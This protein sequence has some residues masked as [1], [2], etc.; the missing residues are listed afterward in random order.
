[1]SASH[2]TQ[3]IAF[4]MEPNKIEITWELRSIFLHSIPNGEFS[5]SLWNQPCCLFL[6]LFFFLPLRLP[7]NQTEMGSENKTKQTNAHKI[8][9][10]ITWN[11][12][13]STKNRKTQ[14][15]LKNNHK[16]TKGAVGTPIKL[17]LKRCFV[18]I[19]AT[20][21]FRSWGARAYWGSQT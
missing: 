6:L 16:V 13:K 4:R 1:M 9:Y 14:N 7:I 11:T 19:F 17:T 5:T 18:T 21:A 12:V 10:D 20:V 3:L 2:A 15:Y 8:V